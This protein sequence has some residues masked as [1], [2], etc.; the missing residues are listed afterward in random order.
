MV[1]LGPGLADDGGGWLPPP[2]ML[3]GACVVVVVV[4]VGV[5]VVLVVVVLVVV[6]VDVEAV[7]G[8]GDV[9]DTRITNYCIALDYFTQGSKK[10]VVVKPCIAKHLFIFQRKHINE[11]LS[12]MYFISLLIMMMVHFFKCFE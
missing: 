9:G 4:V 2:E 5:V 8:G 12:I 6:V 1:Y 7:D 3:G 11:A 10:Q